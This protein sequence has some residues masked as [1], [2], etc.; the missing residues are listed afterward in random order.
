MPS[1]LVFGIWIAGAA[2]ALIVLAGSLI[3]VAYDNWQG[4]V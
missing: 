2:L 3:L 4:N 1:D